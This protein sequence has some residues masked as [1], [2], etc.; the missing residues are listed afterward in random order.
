MTWKSGEQIQKEV[1][2][3][4]TEKLPKFVIETRPTQLKYIL[5]NVEQMMEELIFMP[6][7]KQ[8]DFYDALLILSQILRGAKQIEEEK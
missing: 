2:I 1:H 3:S 7:E 4:M 5:Q 6:E 8:K